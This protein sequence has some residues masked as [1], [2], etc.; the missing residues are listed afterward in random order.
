MILVGFGVLFS[1]PFFPNPDFHFRECESL[2]VKRLTANFDE[3]IKGRQRKG[4]F[5][6][7]RAKKCSATSSCSTPQISFSCGRKSGITR[8]RRQKVPRQFIS[9][10]LFAFL[11]IPLTAWLSTVWTCKCKILLSCFLFWLTQW[12]GFFP[13]YSAFCWWNSWSYNGQLKYHVSLK[14]LHTFWNWIMLI[15]QNNMYLQ[16]TVQKQKAPSHLQ[17]TVDY[18]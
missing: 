11:D 9:F 3:M 7:V 6:Y 15:K 12:R 4:V 17:V 13:V 10:C 5:R 16:Q 18:L 1:P 2:A 14:K 8:K